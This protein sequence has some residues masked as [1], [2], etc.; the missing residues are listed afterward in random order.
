MN[1]KEILLVIWLGILLPVLGATPTITAI[2][3]IIS[4]KILRRALD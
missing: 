3:V 2:L 1:K 4:Y